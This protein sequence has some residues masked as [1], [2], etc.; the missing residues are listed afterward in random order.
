MVWFSGPVSACT[1]LSLLGIVD[2]RGGGHPLC[3]WCRA[4][5]IAPAGLV[6]LIGLLVLVCPE[7]R[8][9]LVIPAD[10]LWFSKRSSG[11]E[12]GIPIIY[13]YIPS[14]W[15]SRKSGKIGF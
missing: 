1:F 3:A 5:F 4:L 12:K 6:G 8:V 7:T 9:D 10:D 14:A 2:E 15:I 13:L 11:L